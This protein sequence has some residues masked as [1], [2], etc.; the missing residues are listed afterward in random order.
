MSCRA[1]SRRIEHQSLKYLFDTLGVDEIEF[2]YEATPRNSPLQG[3]FVELLGS[4]PVAGIS[5]SREQFGGSV[6]A[7]FHRVEGTINVRD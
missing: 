3:F 5:L 1:F 4:P 2:D 6:P 7:L